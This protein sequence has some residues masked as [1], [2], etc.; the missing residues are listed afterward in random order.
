MINI[1]INDIANKVRTTLL[2]GLN[3]ALTGAITASDT[4]LEAFGKLQNQI[5]GKQNALGFT[6]ENVANKDSGTLT[7]SNTTYPTSGAVKTAVDAKVPYSGATSDVN[8]G[9]FGVQLGN[10]EFDTTP[11]N[12]PTTQGSLFWDVDSQ[13]LD[14]VMN[15]VTQKVGQEEFYYVKNQTGSPIAKGTVVRAN[16]T[17]G[18]SGRILIAPF[19]ADGTYPSEYVLGIVAENIADGADG[20]VTSFGK[21]KGVNTNAY[22]D[23]DILYASPTVAGGLTKVKPSAPNNIVTVAIVIKADSNGTLFV[24]PTYGSNINNDEGVLISNPLNNN[25]LRYNSTS[26]LWQND[27]IVSAL[28]FTPENVANKDTSTSLGTSNT[29]YPTQNA[30]KSYV[31]TGLS[32]KENTITT[33]PILKGGTNSGTALNNNRVMQSSG[34]AIVEAPAITANRALISDVNGIPIA[35]TVTDTTLGYLDATSSVQTQLNQALKNIT[36]GIITSPSSH[37]GSAANTILGSILIPAGTLVAGDMFDVYSRSFRTNANGNITVRFY[38]ST[39]A[40][41]I[42][43]ATLLGIMT[44]T[45]AQFTAPVTRKLFVVDNTTVAVFATGSTVVANDENVS[46]V[47]S[48]NETIPTLANDTYLVFTGQLVNGSDVVTLQSAISNRF[49]Q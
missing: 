42:A 43:G 32:G 40:S 34:G 16:G 10:I 20:F 27:T 45:T 31:D 30:V 44:M 21:I 49:R 39:S 11:T 9:E 24:R 38:L 22:L 5:N 4:V 18:N 28:G 29:L 33:L 46:S 48:Q 25:I 26:G 6:P 23:G 1:N 12:T 15:G 41:S 3:T 2:T 7:T 13:T 47:A 8:L 36:L 17:L 19:L 35:S 14:L 37:T